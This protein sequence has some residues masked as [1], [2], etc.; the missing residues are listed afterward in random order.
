MQGSWEGKLVLAEVYIT[1]KA[2]NKGKFPPGNAFD[3]Q[4]PEQEGGIADG[5]AA[6]NAA[7]H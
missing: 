3:R 5:A 4:L 6:P 1:C 2:P 7:E